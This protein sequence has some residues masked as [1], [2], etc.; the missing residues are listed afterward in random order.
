MNQQPKDEKVE[1]VF[2]IS[3]DAE[4]SELANHMIDAKSLGNAILGMDEL[5]KAAAKI[6][7]NGSSEAKLKVL[8]PAQEGS[9]EVVFAILAD[10][11]TTK[12][13]LAGV[14]LI[15]TGLAVGSAT[16][17][18][19]I[20]RLKDRKIDRYSVD[21][22]TKIATLEVEG[23]KIEIP[24]RIAQLVTD[25]TVR[26]ALHK[27][28]KAPVE[29]IEGARVKLL[30]E[31]NTVEVEIA[32]E[33]IGLFDPLKVGSLEEVVTETNQVV[34][35][36]IAL[37]FK[38]KTGWRIQTRDGFECAVH[39]ADEGFMQ[40]VTANEEA[41]QKDKLYTVDLEHEQT[42]RPG[43]TKNTYTIKRVIN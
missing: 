38:G 1:T 28:I 43:N 36:F 32:P 27:V 10:P 8:A 35:K 34:V 40:K 13:L 4:G 30:G 17:I 41:F 2:A 42:R 11:I 29:N 12:A 6:V 37:N 25:K 7:S 39:I 5:I 14:G 23:E 22:N 18:S 24:E 3:Y 33:K 26:A 19:V 15:T 9:L 21:V 20:E 31:N 16:A